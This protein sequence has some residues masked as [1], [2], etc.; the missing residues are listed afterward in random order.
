MQDATL[1]YDGVDPR[2]LKDVELLER[3]DP[4]GARVII[5]KPDVAAPYQGHQT[6]GGMFV[7]DQA[8][9]ALREWGLLAKVLKIAPLALEECP[10]LEP[11]DLVLLPEYAGIPLYLGRETPYWIVGVGDILCRVERDVEE[12]Q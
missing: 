6:Q 10:E 2:F 5:T 1:T 9:R 12:A 3:I 8:K 7:P 4:R 11:G